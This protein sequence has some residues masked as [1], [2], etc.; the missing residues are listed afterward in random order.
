MFTRQNIRGILF[1]MAI[2]VVIALIAYFA[3]PRKALTLRE[4]R[5][6]TA[7]ATTMQ[8]DTLFAFDPNTVTYDELLPRS[9]HC[10]TV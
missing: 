8:R 2:V 6:E 9:L 7:Q 10:A 4:D 1:L 3:E 5:G